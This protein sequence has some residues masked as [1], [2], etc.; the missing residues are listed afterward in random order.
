M[1]NFSRTFFSYT[2]RPQIHCYTIIQTKISSILTFND[3]LPLNCLK[4]RA[5]LLAKN[6][7]DVEG[8]Q[9]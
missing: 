3:S 9:I 6:E 5:C 1:L 4:E 8:I 2:H 7:R